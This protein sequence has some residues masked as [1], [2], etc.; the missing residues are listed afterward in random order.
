MIWSIL[1]ITVVIIIAYLIYRVVDPIGAEQIYNRVY[2]SRQNL[3]YSITT[4]WDPDELSTDET[5]QT[6]ATSIQ[7]V[8]SSD[9][10]DTGIVDYAT[11]S[12]IQSDTTIELNY[13]SGINTTAIDDTVDT[14]DTVLDITITP[15]TV[16]DVPTTPPSYKPATKSTTQQ[17]TRDLSA[18]D[19]ADIRN[20]LNS[21]V[22]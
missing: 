19:Y 12:G 17:T 13:I 15:K 18:Q 3:S 20:L 21:L 11:V 4:R 2:T 14:T 6:Q 8:I 10:L 22:E 7:Q 16:N 1:K 9:S 5:T